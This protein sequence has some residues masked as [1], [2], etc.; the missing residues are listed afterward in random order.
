MSHPLIEQSLVPPHPNLLDL[1]AYKI[2]IDSLL[3]V[4]TNFP[5]L[6]QALRNS[7]IMIQC[8][9]LLYLGVFSNLSLIFNCGKQLYKHSMSVCLSVHLSVGHTSWNNIFKYFH[10]NFMKC[11]ENMHLGLFKHFMENTLEEW[12][13][14]RHADVSQPHSELV[15][16]WLCS[17]DLPHFGG[18]LT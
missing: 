2:L 12:P 16:F 3:L 8:I 5:H 18:I 11:T 13:E 1:F 7:L 10:S 9:K 17:V 6:W 4:F 15:I 14:I